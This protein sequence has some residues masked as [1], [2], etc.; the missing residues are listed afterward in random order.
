M[1]YRLALYAQDLFLAAASLSRNEFALPGG[2]SAGD[3]AS[4]TLL[5][6]IDPLDTSVHW[7][8]ANGE[9]TTAGVVGYLREVLKRDFLD[10]RRSKRAK[11]SVYVFDYEA[12]DVDES[13]SPAVEFATDQ[14]DNP[15]V[16]SLRRE[17]VD[18]LLRQYAEE[19]E[20]QEI[21]RL[22]LTPEGYNAYS[23]QELARML[24]ISVTEV[25]KRK[26]RIKLRLRK[27]A[28]LG[29]AQEAEHV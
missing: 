9:P 27:L 7:S 6:L 16:E 14:S 11:T 19:P 28:R 12:G 4:A 1:L 2:E 15:E 3:L 10:L 20:L 21:L 5:K 17:R 26:K 29:W 23:N 25:E 22:Q 18:W 24:N 8:R 13:G